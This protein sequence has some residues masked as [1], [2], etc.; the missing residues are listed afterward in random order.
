M[1][2]PVNLRL[3]YIDISH[4]SAVWWHRDWRGMAA[5]SFARTASLLHLVFCTVRDQ[6]EVYVQGVCYGG[7]AL[8]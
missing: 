2:G 8:V 3:R 4:G 5:V 7:C 6:R 1:R